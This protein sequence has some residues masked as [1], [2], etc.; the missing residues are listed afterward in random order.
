MTR[1]AVSKRGI[2][3]RLCRIEASAAL[4]LA[5]PDNG[6]AVSSA[7]VSTRH[8]HGCCNTSTLQLDALKSRHMCRRGHCTA[9]EGDPRCC[10]TTLQTD[11]TS[12]Q[13]HVDVTQVHGTRRRRAVD[14][15]PENLLA[16]LVVDLLAVL[17]RPRVGLHEAEGG[18]IGSLSGQRC[19]IREPASLSHRCHSMRAEASQQNNSLGR[20]AAAA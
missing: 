12:T 14:A 3:M 19:S 16:V 13:M 8:G 6:G 20:R 1:A 9:G 10:Y 2:N 7:G 15:S 4:M 18:L 17:L 5:A 11:Q